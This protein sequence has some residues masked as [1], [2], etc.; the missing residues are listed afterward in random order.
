MK[1]KLG[2]DSMDVDS[3][4]TTGVKVF[5][6]PRLS[7]ESVA[8]L[9]FAM[10]PNPAPHIPEIDRCWTRLQLHKWFIQV[11]LQKELDSQAVS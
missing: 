11:T 1:Q 7:S 8:G 9:I 5:N 4:A 2:T 3:A 6:T 10:A